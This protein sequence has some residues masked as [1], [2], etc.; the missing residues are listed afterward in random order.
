[1][2]PDFIQWDFHIKAQKVFAQDA[3]S[4]TGYVQTL[5]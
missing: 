5:R 2:L 4:A 3:Q 1:M